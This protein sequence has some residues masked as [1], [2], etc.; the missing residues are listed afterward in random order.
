MIL[1]L[2]LLFGGASTLILWGVL[3]KNSKN[4][5]DMQEKNISIPELFDAKQNKHNMPKKMDLVSIKKYH[6]VFYLQQRQ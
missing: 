1:I 2:I 4:S 5:L 3:E 6:I